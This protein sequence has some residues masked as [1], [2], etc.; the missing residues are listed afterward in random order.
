MTAGLHYI[1]VLLPLKLGWVPTYS[2]ADPI[3]QGTRVN[4][5]FARR[6]YVGIVLGDDDSK[7]IDYTR[8]Q[9]ILG[10]EEDLAPVSEEELSFWEFISRYYMCTLGE[11]YRAAY[12]SNSVRNE[13]TGSS[14]LKRL[15]VRLEKTEADLL[16][17][18][19][20]K[21]QE[22]LTA[23]ADE[24]RNLI[25]ESRGFRYERA[26]KP[27]PQRPVL[28]H[29]SER[30]GRYFD[31][32]EDTLSKGLQV[33]I[34]TPEIAFCNRI[35]REIAGKPWVLHVTNS[36]RTAVER[37]D[38]SQAARSGR[39]AVF[40]GTR[41]A[42]FLP[43]RNLGT[44]IIDEEQDSSYKQAE[45]APRYNGRDAA[46]ALAGIHHAQVY[47]GSSY[48]SLESLLNCRSGKYGLVECPVNGEFSLIDLGAERRKNGIR[49]SFSIK[50]ILEI[51][52]WDGPVVLI[53]GWEK[54]EELENEARALLQGKEVSIMT[55][56]EIKG[57]D[58]PQGA[59]IAVMQADA[60]VSK[61]DFRCDEKSIQT[62]YL[63]CGLASRV[64]IQCG[65]ESRYANAS[66]PLALL[67]E[68][69]EFGFPPYKRIVDIKRH[70]DNAI[71]ERVF[72]KRDNTLQ[73]KKAELFVNLPKDCYADVDPA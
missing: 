3:S 54:K 24:L 7:D 70:G 13:L 73:E 60:L 53:R 25:E 64:I 10:V 2:S 34:L 65:T 62:A 31:V 14:N 27:V 66:N 57:G 19:S 71:R 12:P 16:K 59:L 32:I 18:H 21:V 52:A 36:T 28:I 72:L 42:L 5:V 1:K 43:F 35:G 63:L 37:R 56:A 46:I 48:P 30:D 47:L 69:K 8:I 15:Q 68:R 41:S 29:G 55:L 40:L 61:D 4:V 22:R 11:V 50:L 44:I 23:K 38:A 67:S 58:C 9:G 6:S 20:S 45:P 39:P 51:M 26:D 33:L 49:G 17:K